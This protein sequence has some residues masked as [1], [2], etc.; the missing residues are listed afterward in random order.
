M[1]KKTLLICFL[2]LNLVTNAFSQSSSLEY[3]PVNFTT[4]FPILS[5]F[6]SAVGGDRV[7]VYTLVESGLSV[8]TF[9][10][11][12]K[13]HRKLVYA[14]LIVLNG[15]G[16]EPWI[17]QMIKNPSVRGRIL[18]TGENLPSYINQ[19]K[20]ADPYAWMDI[21]NAISY[22]KIIRDGLIAV[23]PKYR[24]I[25]ELNASHYIQELEKLN[26]RIVD[27][28]STLNSDSKK[29]IVSHNAYAYFAKAYGLNILTPKTT[30]NR[31]Q[32][33]SKEFSDFMDEIEKNKI[34]TFFIDPAGQNETANKIMEQAR[35]K[36]SGILYSEDYAPNKKT[37][38]SYIELMEYNAQT[39]FN[40]LNQAK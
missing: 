4:S 11:T 8:A 13:D 31:K 23:D 40:A 21:Q 20:I 35:L 19:N 1:F 26:K 38:Q 33:S 5:D 14:E 34:R 7:K 6:A 9:E 29:I 2:A 32:M 39:I 12:K 10:A 30:G 27:M 15:L 25:Y 17:D 36:S 24:K 3:Q 28:F 16:F 18:I 37:P 22:V